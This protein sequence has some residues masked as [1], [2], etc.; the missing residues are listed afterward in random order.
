MVFTVA[1]V[2]NKKAKHKA[3]AWEL[4]SYLTGKQGMTEWTE[5]GIAL[6]TKKR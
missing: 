6:P 3:E 1:Y 2:M 5:N 4:I